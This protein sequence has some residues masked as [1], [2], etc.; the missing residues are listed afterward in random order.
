MPLVSSLSHSKDK[1]RDLLAREKTAKIMGPHWL[2]IT[3]HGHILS[4]DA[5]VTE[6]VPRCELSPGVVVI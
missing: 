6:H 5:I 1:I 2:A 4:D 3:A